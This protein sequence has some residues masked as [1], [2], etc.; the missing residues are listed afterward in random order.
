MLA[1]SRHIIV[2]T[3]MYR[4]AADTTN[5]SSDEQN[6]DTIAVVILLVLVQHK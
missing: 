1:T 3:S 5:L 4:C 6:I 2:F